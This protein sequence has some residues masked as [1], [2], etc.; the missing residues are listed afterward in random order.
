[1]AAL[2]S[3]AAGLQLASSST[4]TVSLWAAACGPPQGGTRPDRSGR[5]AVGGL[6]GLA[7]PITG[8][9]IGH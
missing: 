1:M 8:V 2:A 9:D 3:M 7:Q 4:R 6:V 5:P